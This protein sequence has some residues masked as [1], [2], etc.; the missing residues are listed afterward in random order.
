MGWLGSS[1]G[2]NGTVH[3]LY[4]PYHQQPLEAT[5]EPLKLVIVTQKVYN[6]EDRCKCNG[7]FKMKGKKMFQNSD[8][9]LRSS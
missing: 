3:W 1:I 4:I 7:I 5:V 2:C 9:N 8:N 6:L